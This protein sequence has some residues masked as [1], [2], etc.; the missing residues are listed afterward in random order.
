MTKNTALNELLPPHLLDAC[1]PER[2]PVGGRLFATGKK[3]A[4]MFYVTSGEVLLE[5][6]A[7]DGK[8]VCLQ[9]CSDGFVGEASLTSTKYHCDASA[10][11]SSTVIKVPLRELRRALSEDSQFA[12]R[13]IRMLNKEVRSLRMQNERLSL[14][15]VEER[16]MHLLESDG[17][18]GV[19]VL[20][21]SIKEMAKGLAVTH[22]A[23]YRTLSKLEARGVL[24]RKDNIL[25][26]KGAGVDGLA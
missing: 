14:P 4:W 26:L 11:Q 16:L 24:I 9:R 21:H 18:Q 3:P 10:N 22:E 25:T 7:T 17:E 5:R 23:L 19:Y 2:Y 6:H 12:L 13:W 15:K 20:K 1:K 8:V